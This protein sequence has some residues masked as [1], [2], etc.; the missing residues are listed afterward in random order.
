[1]NVFTMPLK[2][3]YI[4]SMECT[5][6]LEACQLHG[7]IVTVISVVMPKETKSGYYLGGKVSAL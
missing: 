5:C 6:N 1:M 3:V 4:P 7:N 2:N